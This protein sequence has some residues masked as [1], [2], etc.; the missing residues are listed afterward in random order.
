MKG[1]EPVPIR[2]YGEFKDLPDLPLEWVS[3]ALTDSMIY[4]LSTTDSDGTPHTRPVHGAFID[5]RLLLTNGSRVHHR[6]LVDRGRVSVHVGS[7]AEVVILEGTAGYDPEIGS[8]FYDIYKPKYGYT[9]DMST[10]PPP[11]AV[12][13]NSILAWVAKGS[14]GQDGWARAAKWVRG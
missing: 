1:F 13:P 12:I 4:W 3:A 14:A 2:F 9:M 5:D 11:L 6:N 7:G 10:L 8:R